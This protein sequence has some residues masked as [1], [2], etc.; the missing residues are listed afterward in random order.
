MSRRLITDDGRSPLGFKNVTC[1]QATIETDNLL[2][3]CTTNLRPSQGQAKNG[4]V[5]SGLRHLVW[6]WGKT[7]AAG[8][9]STAGTRQAKRC[10][11]AA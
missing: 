7:E 3:K 8:C 10:F 11:K 4:E 2:A 1:Q 5:E 9:R 6:Y